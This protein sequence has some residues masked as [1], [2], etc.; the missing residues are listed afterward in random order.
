MVV[1]NNK[2]MTTKNAGKV[3]AILIA[4][5]MRQYNAR[6]IARW[7][8]YRATLEATGCCHWVSACAAPAAAMVDEFV[9]ITHNTNKTQLLA[10]NYGT[11][12]SLAVYENF[13]PKTDPLLSSYATSCVKMWDSRIRAGEL[14]YISS[15]QMLSVDKHLKSY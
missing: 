9:E 6:R 4:M 13:N 5:R 2:S 3:L 1:G 12:R 14:S 11:L 7:S 15:Y 10:G 8:T